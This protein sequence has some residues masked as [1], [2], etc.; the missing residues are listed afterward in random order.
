MAM[1]EFCDPGEGTG[2]TPKMT[3][4]NSHA[5]TMAKWHHKHLSFHPNK[6]ALPKVSCDT[7]NEAKN[8]KIRDRLEDAY[9]KV[10]EIKESGQESMPPDRSIGRR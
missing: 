2:V 10:Q 9:K 3:S 5:C 4:D 7:G 6:H 8:D 1:A